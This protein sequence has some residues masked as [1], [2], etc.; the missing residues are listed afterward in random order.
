M[1]GDGNCLFRTLSFYLHNNENAHKNL[2]ESAYQYVTNNIT[3]F[4]EY[5]Y[6]KNG[7]YYIDIKEGSHIKKYILDD[8]VEKIKKKIFFLK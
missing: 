6:L 1:T 5:C 2:R 4:Y 3:N 7:F 8:Y